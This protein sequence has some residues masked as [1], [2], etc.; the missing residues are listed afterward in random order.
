[1]YSFC[2]I[3]PIEDGEVPEYIFMDD[4]VNRAFKLCEKTNENVIR[5]AIYNVKGE[6][7][8]EKKYVVY[9]NENI[10]SEITEKLYRLCVDNYDRITPSDKYRDKV[11]KLL[12]K[13]LEN[14]E[15]IVAIYEDDNLIGYSAG[16]GYLEQ[17]CVVKKYDNRKLK[18]VL[19]D[20]IS[21]N[22]FLKIK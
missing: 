2:E 21:E 13:D 19:I 6:V 22:K 17:I 11:L 1:M 3:Y 15:C 14:F 8:Y 10:N 16:N 7:V 5:I 12:K 4:K 20:Y 9:T 18:K